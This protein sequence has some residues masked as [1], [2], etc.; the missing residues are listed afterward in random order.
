MNPFP[1]AVSVR[2]GK[3]FPLFQAGRIVLS[4]GKSISDALKDFINVT[5][6]SNE[7]GNIKTFSFLEWV[8]D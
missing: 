6:A 8:G 2:W 4:Q 1:L 3:V 5:D 7:K